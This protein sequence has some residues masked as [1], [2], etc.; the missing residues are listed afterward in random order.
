[1]KYRAKKLGAP[2]CILSQTDKNRFDP[3]RT[4]RFP[5]IRT[6]L[7]KDVV[8]PAVTYSNIFLAIA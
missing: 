8:K 2:K 4:G 5:Y 6:S 7:V 1:V 3:D